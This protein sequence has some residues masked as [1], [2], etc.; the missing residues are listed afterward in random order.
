MSN[1]SAIA[2]T[3]FG[4]SARSALVIQS[5]PLA[6]PFQP[7]FNNVTRKLA[8]FHVEHS[9]EKDP[10]TVMAPKWRKGNVPRGTF[11]PKSETYALQRT[12]CSG[13]HAFIDTSA[14]GWTGVF[15]VERS[16]AGDATSPRR[17]LVSERCDGTKRQVNRPREQCCLVFHVEHADPD[18]TSDISQIHFEEA[19]AQSHIM[20]HVEHLATVHPKRQLVRTFCP[21][22]SHP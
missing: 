14:G 5:K 19:G 1:Q 22:Q 13:R 7:D 18:S 6:Q 15:H 2:T 8:T 4:A 20:F 21:T 11:R 10:Y 9:R 12:A 16:A 17:E 3:E